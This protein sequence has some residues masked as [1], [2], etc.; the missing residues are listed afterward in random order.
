MNSIITSRF[1]DK[2][3][4]TLSHNDGPAW[5]A[6]HIGELLGYA[7][8]HLSQRLRGSWRE[9]L[10]EGFDYAVVTGE[11]ALSVMTAQGV[12]VEVPPTGD[13][14]VV[15]LFERGLHIIL[16]KTGTPA[17]RQLRL[18]LLREVIPRLPAPPTARKPSLEER[19]EKRLWAQQDLEERRLASESL[20]R[21]VSEL[22]RLGYINAHVRAVYEVTAAEIALDNELPVLQ[23]AVAD[24]PSPTA[25]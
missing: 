12:P 18:F 9:Q 1:G 21:T 14:R 19:R 8:N 5:D 24:A 16:A 15:L 17:A 10:I 11:D 4:T 23:A 7:G 13:H 20:R 22:H 6:N 25:A 2:T 3:L